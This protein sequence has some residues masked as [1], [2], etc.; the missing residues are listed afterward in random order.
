MVSRLFSGLVAVR[1]TVAYA[2]MLA[3]VATTLAVLG[4]RV[5]G[6]VV[7]HLSTNLHNL[8]Q[9]H[10][11][12]LVGSAFVTDG[13][14]IY[15]WLPGLVCLLAVAELFWRGRLVV[16]FA[17][18]H[19]GSTLIVAV[20]LVVAIR[21]GWLPIS[22]AGATDVGIS[23]GAVA[24]L[25][26]LTAAIPPGWR[27]AWVGWWL[28]IALVVAASGEDFDF[29]ATGHTVGLALGVLLSTRFR[30][31]AQWTPVRLV[32]LA[33]G[34]AFG[35]LMLTGSAPLAAPVAGVAGVLIALIGQWV[36]RRWQSRR[37]HRSVAVSTGFPQL[38]RAEPHQP[39]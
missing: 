1:L 38:T 35:Y 11:G 9:G 13:G 2:V 22:V 20:V 10:L 17:L 3:V 37:M 31:A 30:S 36:A 7:T 24:V 32:L 23:Y 39:A 33:G 15:V 26:A 29:T 16:A 34:G 21:F 28:A 19:I 27:P 18:G 6:S 8:A 14:Q 4:P 5:Q 25:G 12:T